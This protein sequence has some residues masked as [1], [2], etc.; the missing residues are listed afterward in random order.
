M[1][2]LA[3]CIAVLA[4]GAALAQGAATVLKQAAQSGVAASAP[5]AAEPTVEQWAAELQ[6]A[7]ADQERLLAATATAGDVALLDDRRGAMAQLVA[8]LAARV[9]ASRT[10]APPEPPIVPT[11]LSG[12]PP[13]P[14]AEVDGLRDQ[15]DGLQA[16]R[17]SLG[18]TL[19]ALDA[20][21]EAAVQARRRAEETLRLRQELLERRRAGDNPERLRAQ[22]E[23]ARAQVRVAELEAVRADALR[24]KARERLAGVIDAQA[25]L[26]REIARV[27]PAQRLDDADI[28]AQRERT[29][30][31]LHRLAAERTRA[32][33]R[34]ARRE[35]RPGE[36]GAPHA[37]EVEAL[38]G[39]VAALGD[40]ETVARGTDE[41]WQLRQQALAAKGDRERQRAAAVTLAG[42]IAQVQARERAAAE[43]NDLI[44]S[45]LRLQQARL[46][47]LEEGDPAHVAEQRA[48]AAQQQLVDVR[49]RVQ[50]ARAR[51]VVLL[52]RSREDLDV[53]ERPDSASGWLREAADVVEDVLRRIWQFELFS[54]TETTEIDGR[55]VQQEYGV[56]VGKSIGALVLLLVGYLSARAV[57]SR[58]ITRAAARLGLSPE[59]T[60]VLRRWVMSILVLVVAVVVLKLARIPLTAFAFLGGALAI[61]VGFGAQN[62]IKNLISG[63]IILFERKIRVGDIVTIGGISGTVTS[64]DLRATTVLGF[65][66]IESIVPNSML[67]ENQVSNWSYGS[68]VVRRAIVVGVAYGSDMRLACKLV[69]DCAARHPSVLREPA[70]AVYFDDF[71]ADALTIRLL[72]W[73]RL[74]GDLGGPAVDSDL[75]FAIYG[76]LAEAGIEIAF[77]QRDVHLDVKAPLQ[78]QLSAQGVGADA[79]GRS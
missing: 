53:A 68:P 58:L 5:R 66:G 1:A 8:L 26:E 30:A 3:C 65:D 44:R 59:L 9:E 40:L 72:Y 32:A 29:A 48:L 42:A 19:K 50:E 49:A 73:L 55:N 67:L 17:D 10:P 36:D 6:Q 75:R 69:G 71:G 64:V 52:S 33:E 35:A 46:A 37:R 47:A 62:V 45:E 70:S 34:L 41:I 51:T 12:P 18:A 15:R 25:S 13:Y 61:G 16:H 23:L 77:P 4:S 76:A 78:V 63:I 11:L 43:Q 27:R 79:S 60:Q 54:V 39:I 20:E 2:R 28:A 7:K 38:R 57:T 31:E 22:V 74:G 24:S 21:V 56:T 14:V